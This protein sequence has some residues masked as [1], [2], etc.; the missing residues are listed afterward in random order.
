MSRNGKTFL[1]KLGVSSLSCA[2]DSSSIG[3]VATEN[4]CCRIIL[5]GKQMMR[6][7][8]RTGV[9]VDLRKVYCDSSTPCLCLRQCDSGHYYSSYTDT[10][11]HVHTYASLRT[12]ARTHA[13]TYKHT[14]FILFIHKFGS[15]FKQSVEIGSSFPLSDFVSQED[16]SYQ[17]LLMCI[18]Q[19]S[20]ES[21]ASCRTGLLDWFKFRTH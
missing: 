9:F 6:H 13:H 21:L 18:L 17:K 7:C 2:V 15:N 1:I 4:Q 12:C 19:F 14:S 8:L 3:T 20:L 10:H 5:K 11:K 16:I